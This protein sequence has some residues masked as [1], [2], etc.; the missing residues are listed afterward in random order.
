MK[1]TKTNICARLQHDASVGGVHNI[2]ASCW[3]SEGRNMVPSRWNGHRVYV[4]TYTYHGESIHVAIQVITARDD[5][6]YV[7]LHCD[8]SIHGG[9]TIAQ[10]VS[11]W[12][13]TA[14]ARVPARVKT[15]GIC[16]GQSDTGGRFSPS[17]SVSPANLHSSN[18]SIIS[19][20][21]DWYNR[22]IVATVTQSRPTKITKIIISI[23]GMDLHGPN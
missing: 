13:P 21:W 20:I 18:Y 5:N 2:H 12:L 8:L 3:Q 10:A 19:I 22:P 15:C 16:G 14:A 17:T 4:S 9:R 7:L 6:T 23:H 11:R 1:I